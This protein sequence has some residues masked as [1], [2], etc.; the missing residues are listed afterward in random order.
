MFGFGV[1]LFSESIHVH[2]SKWVK[3]RI[4]NF[5]DVCDVWLRRIT[6]LVRVYMFINQSGKSSSTLRKF[7]KVLR[8]LDTHMSWGKASVMS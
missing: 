4:I 6:L 2:Q 8:P 1:W 5:L 3:L 7:F